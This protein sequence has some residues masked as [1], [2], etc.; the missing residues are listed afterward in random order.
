MKAVKRGSEETKNP[1]SQ[2]ESKSDDKSSSSETGSVHSSNESDK[3]STMASK[4]TKLLFKLEISDW[5]IFVER[6][7]IRFK[8]KKIKEE[9]K[10]ADMLNH[11]DE[12]VYSLLRNLGAPEK[13]GDKGYTELKKVTDYVSPAP[14]EVMERF[15]FNQGKN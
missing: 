2:A 11:I 14:L 13:V 4:H 7:E 3:D 9:D 6:L 5:G 8:A 15:T 12:E 10:A 1:G